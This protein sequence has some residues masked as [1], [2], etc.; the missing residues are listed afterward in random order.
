MANL[1]WLGPGFFGLDV[2][3]GD[4]M[5][6]ID[7]KRLEKFIKDGRVGTI[8]EKIDPEIFQ[9]EIITDLEK[10]NSVLEKALEKDEKAVN[11]LNIII[12]DLKVKLEVSEKA[13]KALEKKH[14][15]LEKDK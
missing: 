11:P 14:G 15:P 10:D 7:K 5:P 12:E 2:A 4:N 13:L 3:P 9:K 1:K 8:A 6:K